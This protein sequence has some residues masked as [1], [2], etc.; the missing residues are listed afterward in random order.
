MSKRKATFSL[1]E[2][3]LAAVDEAVAAGAARNKNQLVE[4]ALINEVQHWLRQERKR[5]WVEAVSDP[6]F[7]K[8]VQ[9]AEDDFAGAEAHLPQD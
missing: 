9:D 1:P 7:L 4:Q 5:R 3:V 8:D 6:L 2:E